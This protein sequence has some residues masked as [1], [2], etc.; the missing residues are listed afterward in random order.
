[1]QY[2][3]KA[4]CNTS[5]EMIER[6]VYADSIDSVVRSVTSELGQLGYRMVSVCRAIVLPTKEA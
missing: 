5:F 1:M 6:N 3:V 2:K 4:R